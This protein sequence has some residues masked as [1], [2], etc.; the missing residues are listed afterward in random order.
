MRIGIHCTL[1]FVE[2]MS[3]QEGKAKRR[4]WGK[5]KP[6][7]EISIINHEKIEETLKAIAEETKH[8]EVSLERSSSNL[9]DLQYPELMSNDALV[10]RLKYIKVPIPV[11]PDGKPSRERLLH[12]YKVHVLP[13]PQR[14]KWR[15][16]KKKNGGMSQD[17]QMEVDDWSVKADGNSSTILQRKRYLSASIIQWNL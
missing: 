3:T 9:T 13:R 5:T 11:Y 16:R 4:S 12:L 15:N 10:T 8:S 2:K 7:E 6:R 1:T 17:D 14:A